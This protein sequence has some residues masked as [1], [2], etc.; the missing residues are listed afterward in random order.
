MFSRTGRN[1]QSR[2]FPHD[3][4]HYQHSTTTYGIILFCRDP[5]H[6][7]DLSKIQYLL[8]QR[9]DSISY[10]EFIKNGTAKGALMEMHIG[11]MSDDERLRCLRYHDNNDFDTLWDDFCVFE[12]S[13][14][15][16]T[17]KDRCKLMFHQNME[18]YRDVF[19]RCMSS[20]S[21]DVLHTTTW[22]FPKGRA[23]HSES[24]LA[25]ALREFEEETGFSRHQ[26]WVLDR[27]KCMNELY[28]GTNGKTYR[29][30]YF[31]A[32][33][34]TLL[35]FP[36]KKQSSRS[37]IR[38]FYHTDEIAQLTW[39]TA[40]EAKHLITTTTRPL[41]CCES[42]LSLLNKSISIISKRYML[43]PISPSIEPKQSMVL[44]G[45]QQKRLLSSCPPRVNHDIQIPTRK[46]LALTIN[47]VYPDDACSSIH[48]KPNQPQ[49]QEQ[50]NLQWLQ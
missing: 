5:K 20:T 6:P 12:Q 38:P 50:S 16:S 3:N 47:R 45:N 34:G 19:I 21:P 41:S 4:H 28:I 29:T 36:I 46:R 39:A 48:Q 40:D 35:P 44:S 42:R 2:Y 37:K 31:L 11:L 8:G 7:N 32:E 25:C 49:C 13:N 1:Y 30:V 14:M 26:I 33:T 24:E 43:D 23:Q 15:W 27:N 17:L 9:R 18:T 10:W 22:H